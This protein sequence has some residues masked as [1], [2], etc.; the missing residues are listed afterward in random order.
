MK[1]RAYIDTQYNV[2]APKISIGCISDKIDY[3]LLEKQNIIDC[4]L[5]LK[6]IDIIEICF[7]N[8]D[9]LDDNVVIIIKL[10]S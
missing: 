9:D 4:N 8:K 2:T 6:D 7:L 3:V 10:L 1:V 5:E